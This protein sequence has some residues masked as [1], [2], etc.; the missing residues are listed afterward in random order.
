MRK[1]GAQQVNPR[2]VAPGDVVV[3]LKGNTGKHIGIMNEGGNVLNNSSGRKVWV[4]RPLQDYNRTF[5]GIRVWRM[6][7]NNTRNA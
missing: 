5:S 6:P 2:D 1:Q 4:D 7:D 3:F